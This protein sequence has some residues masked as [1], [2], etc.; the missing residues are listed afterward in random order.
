M[1]KMTQKEIVD[2][3][4]KLTLEYHAHWDKV[5]NSNFRDYRRLAEGKLP[6]KIEQRMK[7]DRYRLR[8]KLT[9]RTIPNALSS[10]KGSITHNLFHRQDKFEF[11]GRGDED[12]QRAKDGNKVVNYGWD[13]TDVETTAGEI[14]EDSL[15]V[16]GG[17]GEIVHWIDRKKTMRNRGGKLGKIE[18]VV[19]DGALLKYL[20]TELVYPEPVRRFDDITAYAKILV[21]PIWDIKKQAVNPKDAYY[22]FRNNVKKLTKQEFTDKNIKYDVSNDHIRPLNEF[23]TPGFKVQVADVWVL[24]QPDTKQSPAWYNIVIGNYEGNPKLIRFER[25]PMDTGKHPLVMCRVFPRNNRLFGFS[26]P[27]MLMSLFLEKFAKRNQRIDYGN[28]FLAMASTLVAEQGVIKKGSIAFD[29]NKVIE[30]TGGNANDVTTIKMDSAPI[31]TSLQEEAVV[32]NDVDVTLSTNR[33]S[34]GLDPKRREAATTIAVVD[35]NAKILQS[36]PLRSI[37]RTLIKPTAQRYL[38]HAQNFSDPLFNIR[39]LGAEGATFASIDKNAIYGHFDVICRA[40]SE[41]LPKAI[42]QANIGRIAQIYGANPRTNIDMNKLAIEDM[43]ISEI[44]NPESFIRTET[45]EQA[46]ISREEGALM[47]GIAWEPLEHENHAMHIASHSRLMTELLQQGVEQTDVSIISLQTHN[48]KHQQLMQIINGQ[49]N[50]GQ[51]QGITSIGE[52]LNTASATSA[53]KA[54]G[55]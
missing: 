17:F 6:V 40:S 44:S 18:D 13:V 35:E 1:A 27:E 38:E 16:G 10:L 12:H 43:R 2:L 4:N 55:G 22:K 54:V 14:I 19:Y 9:P 29:L 36:Q 48:S 11:I 51:Q 46:I 47:N 33:V 26:A 21:L 25:D 20:R 5:Y 15:E 53:P 41:V 7:T 3:V 23:P 24:F 42:K 45:E 31:T 32:D 30:L 50:I 28:Q 34:R 52:G 8:S 39:I 49:L 37:E